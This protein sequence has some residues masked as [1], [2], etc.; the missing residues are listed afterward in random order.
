MHAIGNE[1]DGENIN[2][3]CGATDLV[4]LSHEV[5]ERGLDLGVAFDGDGDRMLAVDERGEPLDGDQI[6]AILALALGVDLVAVTVMTNLG[7]HR[8]MA[9]H[10]IRVVTT[11]VGDR[12]V[13]E[14]LHRDG[15]LLGGEQSGHVI[16][17]GNHVAGDGLA[18]ALLLCRALSGRKLSE[19]A[20]VMTRFPQAKQNVQVLRRE[21]PQRSSTRP[22]ASRKSSVK[23]R[24]LVRPSGT[25][26][27]LQV[28]AEAETAEE[29]GKNLPSIAA[30]VA[31]EL[32]LPDGGRRRALTRFPGGPRGVGSSDT[33][34]HVSRSR[35]SCRGSSDSNTADTTR[36]GS[37]LLEDEGLTYVR[38]VGPLENLIKPRD[39]RLGGDHRPRAH[40]LGDATARSP[41]RMPTR[42]PAGDA[43]RVSIVL[44][45]IVENYRG[46][47]RAPSPMVTPSPRRP[48]Q[49]PSPTS[50]SVTTKATWSRPYGSPSPSSKGTS[51]SSSSTATIPG[52]SSVRGTRSRSSSGSAARRC[53]SP[54]TRPPSSR[55]RAL[56]EF[57][58]DGE[59]VAV[60][61]DGSAYVNVDGTPTEHE[62]VE[63]DWDDEGAE[64]AGYETFML[65]EIYEQ[66]DAVAETIGDRVR[67]RHARPR[68]PRHVRPGREGASAHRPRRGGTAYHACVVGRYVIEEWA[69]IP[70]EF[71]IASEWVY[72]NPVI[73]EHT[74]VI[75]ISQSGETRDTIEALKLAREKGARTVAITNMMG[76]QITREVDSVLYTRRPRDVGRILEDVHR[77]GCAHL[78]RRTQAGE[79]TRDALPGEIEFILDYVYK[80]PRKIHSSSRPT[81]RS[82]RSR[83]ATTTR[84]SSSTSAGTSVCR[85]RSRVR[86]S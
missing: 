78:S 22:T 56:V 38:A 61:P 50:S 43:A 35:C 20:S 68:R 71:D 37:R 17:L 28:L 53:S 64:K 19:A 1:P 60:T 70:V 47:A 30:L 3:G 51:R 67:A 4:A 24:V 74:L 52:S 57:P 18:A 2:V 73:D 86:S 7:F 40:A 12:Y 41:S 5:L 65:K 82:R 29:A 27:P 9:D 79:G 77:P 85:S 16:W 75:G 32:D 46:C 83:A 80:L 14:A 58:G 42:L 44:N 15:G 84:P 59:I 25:G 62:R 49:R 72:R 45:G 8:L 63:L 10:G 81:T 54:R 26:N 39:E 21:L 36:P 66:P 48:T 55:K 69:R 6:L 13:L 31:K 34:D 33:S 76:S 23:G 11:P